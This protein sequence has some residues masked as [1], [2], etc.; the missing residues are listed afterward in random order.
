[1]QKVLPLPLVRLS[2]LKVGVVV[3]VPEGEAG[4]TAQSPA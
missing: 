4:V 2:D 3:I 1:M